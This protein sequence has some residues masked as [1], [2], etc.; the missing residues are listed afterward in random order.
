VKKLIAMVASSVAFGV[1]W[2]ASAS[3]AGTP[4]TITGPDVAPYYASV[5]LNGTT[6]APNQTVVIYYKAGDATRYTARWT[7][8]SDAAA[9]F[10]K[11]YRIQRAG[12]Y[13][14]RSGGLNSATHSIRLPSVAC[15]VSRPLFRHLPISPEA[16]Y[17]HNPTF[18]SLTAT[19]DGVWGG[20]EVDTRSGRFAVLRWKAGARRPTTLAIY[21]YFEY[22]PTPGGASVDVVGISSTGAVVARVQRRD[23]PPD[24]SRE[25]GRVWI[26]KQAHPLRR[27]SQSWI[28]VTP[29][30]VAL[31]DSIY[32]WINAATVRH[33]DYKVVRWAPDGTHPHVLADTADQLPFSVV[34]GAGDVSYEVGATT[35]VRLASGVVFQLPGTKPNDLVYTLVGG[36][37]HLMFGGGDQGVIRWRVGLTVRRTLLAPRSHN[38]LRA[39]GPHG[40]IVTGLFFRGKRGVHFRTARG[41]WMRFPDLAIVSGFAIN[42]R[43][44]VA[45]TSAKDHLVHLLRCH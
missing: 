21:K 39:A 33:P 16:Y 24:G 34:D 27:A 23:S 17:P 10:H 43:G 31:D 40:E 14:A 44:A 22:E 1:S 8:H 32:G 5:T 29:V 26:G 38:G 13:Y 36:V 12:S 30:G 37:R 28:S 11:S 45:Y 35:F 20:V 3:F 18:T 41:A 4:P 19:R 42:W 25:F 9:R 7:L 2:T 6:A 15:S